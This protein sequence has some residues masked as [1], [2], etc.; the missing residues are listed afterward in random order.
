MAGEDFRDFYGATYAPLCAQLYVLTGNIDA[1]QNLT[2]AAFARAAQRWDRLTRD[3]DPVTWVRMDAWRRA[4]RWHIPRRPAPP[5]TTESRAVQEWTSS[6]PP[7]L[8]ALPIPARQAL[9]LHHV[10]GMPVAEIGAIIAAADGVVRAWLAVAPGDDVGG[11]LR[12]L[13]DGVL[14]LIQPPGV[15]HPRPLSPRWVVSGVGLA[16]VA[17]A[18]VV[19]LALDT[20]TTRVDAPVGA[21]QTQVPWASPSI[22]A[23]ADTSI[24]PTLSPSLTQS[25]AA[26]GATGVGPVDTSSDFV[27]G[28]G[29]DV[30]PTMSLQQRIASCLH[31]AE[32]AT[33]V[34][35]ASLVT[36]FKWVDPNNQCPPGAY[37]RLFWA[38]YYKTADGSGALFASGGPYQVD[39][40]TPAVQFTIV[41]PVG[42][43]TYFVVTGPAAVKQTLT[44]AQMAGQ[45]EAYPST[46]VP[47]AQTDAMMWNVDPNCQPSSARPTV[48]A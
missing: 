8:A 48:T 36:T 31:Q 18:V 3:E 38:S 23:S 47:P 39:N 22:S 10:A 30:G 35:D 9:V 4:R 14:P 20:T 45:V 32:M 28:N 12:Q 25:V 5:R 33:P 2:Q 40:A 29:A 15:P 21:G 41:Y 24:G 1:A 27:G 37:A 44:A 17:A 34:P 19:L 13:R 11:A 6:W 26:T 7:T 46:L 42:C 43:A 16:A